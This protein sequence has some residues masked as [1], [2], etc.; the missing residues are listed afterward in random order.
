MCQFLH[1]NNRVMALDHRQNF[2]ST[3]YLENDLMKLDQIL[4]M[5]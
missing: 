1:I 3:Q 5:H 2:V 4:Q